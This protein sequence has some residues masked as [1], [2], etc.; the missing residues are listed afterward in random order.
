MKSCA[1]SRDPALSK[2]CPFQVE[3]D[4]SLQEPEIYW[5]GVGVGMSVRGPLQAVPVN[6]QRGRAHRPRSDQLSLLLLA[7]GWCLSYLM[8][9]PNSIES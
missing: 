3:D 5:V 1:G 7:Q 8:L 4:G 6:G 9:L 2:C